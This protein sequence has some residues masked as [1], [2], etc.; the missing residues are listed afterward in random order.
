MTRVFD[1]IVLV[2]FENQYRSYTLRD[3]FLDKLRRAGMDLGNYFGCF[4]PSQTNYIASLFGEVCAVTN[5]DPPASPLIGRT[6]VDALE[7]K[8]LSWKAY[9]EAYPGEPWNPAWQDAGYDASQQPIGKYPDTGQPLA[10]YFR[11]HNAFASA[12]AVQKDP[13]RWAKIVDDGQFWSDVMQG[14]LPDYSWFT[15]DIWN[16]GHY[17]YNT[18]LEPQP[19]TRL[20]PQLSNYLEYVFFGDLPVDQITCNAAQGVT[21]IGLNL[22]ID[23]LLSDPDAAWAQSRVPKGTLIV[24]TF[25]EADFNAVGYDTNYDGPNQVYTVLLGDMIPPGTS[26]AQPLN[27][28]GMIRTVTRNFGLNGLRKNDDGANW[29]RELWG[30][31]FRW[32]DPRAML[33]SGSALAAGTLAGRAIIA[34]FAE[35][36]EIHALE[37]EAWKPLGHLPVTPERVALASDADGLV[38]LHA[39]NNAL[40]VSRSADGVTWDDAQALR[41]AHPTGD[42]AACTLNIDSKPHVLAAWVADRGFIQTAL[43][44]GERWADVTETGHRTDGALVAGQIGGSAYLVYKAPGF[45]TMR[46]CSMNLARFNAFKALNFKGEPAPE[47]DTSYLKWSPADWSVGNFARKLAAV[48]ND[49]RAE[50]S[51]ALASIDGEMRLVHRGAYDDTPSTYSEAFSLTGIFTPTDQRT[52]GF[53]TLDQAGWTLEE[54]VEA[55]TLAIDSAIALTA[56]E[57]GYVLIWQEK[58][59]GEFQWRRGGYDDA[60]SPPE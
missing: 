47:N 10:S 27:H 17:V 9:M 22:N 60:V 58:Q 46:H 55:T 29:L 12:H 2:M 57:Q 31:T 25:D 43:W 7:E 51:L 8:G 18:H 42:I 24:V 53:G 36:V 38:L 26:S 23:L 45:R 16:D 32:S 35:C 3:P 19:R 21:N 37:G 20:I 40:H 6:L 41:G 11:K 52:N 49:Y 4:H 15:P 44:D 14:T 56:D 1:R 54:T 59:G 13:E 5:D 50:G 28:F 39:E 48:Q 30:E 33:V 34:L